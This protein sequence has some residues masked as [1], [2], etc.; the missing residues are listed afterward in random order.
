MRLTVAVPSKGN[1][2]GLVATLHALRTLQSGA[3][4]VTLVAIVDEPTPELSLCPYAVERVGKT[5]TVLAARVNEV[6]RDFPADWY[7]QVNDDTL[8][9]TQDWDKWFGVPLPAFC[10]QEAKDPANV[11][12]LAL[13]DKWFQAA[14]FYA[15][16]FP[17]WFADTWIA[18]VHRLAFGQ[19]LPQ[20][21]GLRLGGQ[22]GKTRGLRDLDFWFRFFAATRPER[23]EQ[24]RRVAEAFDFKM[25]DPARTVAL[26]EVADA[27]QLGRVTQYE[28]QFMAQG[29]PSAL[30]LQAK[31]RAQAHLEGNGHTA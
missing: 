9:L 24:A 20:L 7:A 29:E 10:W 25:P 19:G 26:L 14:G 8:P 27:E 21:A 17:F 30:Y 4:E 13:S 3:N 18:E 6:F 1:P 2:A 28:Q 16:W 23:V 12:Y 11:T 31:A 5:K 22:R 15:E